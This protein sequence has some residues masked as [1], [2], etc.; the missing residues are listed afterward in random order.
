MDEHNHY[1]R[2]FH[3][4]NKHEFKP[5]TTIPL[6]VISQCLTLTVAFTSVNLNIEIGIGKVRERLQG[7]PLLLLAAMKPS[8][9]LPRWVM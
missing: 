2:Y 3:S 8:P 1:D 6:Y 9:S 5:L 4:Q 7:A